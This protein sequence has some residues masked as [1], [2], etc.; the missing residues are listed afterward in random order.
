M[1]KQLLS[2]LL[3][4]FSI[5]TASSA[6]QFF[7]PTPYLQ[8]SDSPFSGGNFAY[9][10]LENFEDRSLNTPGVSANAAGDFLSPTFA[11]SVDADDGIIDGS[12]SQGQALWGG[13]SVP[14]FTF[15]FDANALGGLP[16]HAG[17]VWTDANPTLLGV[18]FEAFGVNG[19]SLGTIG[20]ETLGDGL[21]TGQTAEDRF[22]GVSDPLGI[23]AIS[24]GVSLGGNWELDH[25]QY[26]RQGDSVT[27]PPVPIP[28]ALLLFGSAITGLF[29]LRSTKNKK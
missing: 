1:K 28:S 25:L 7:G 26:G 9:Y 10:H 17:V 27:P 2:L 4:G 22:F 14:K 15:T 12:G 18:T 29:G 13:G 20:P 6:A 24:L 23:S 5:S 3:I 16:T 21:L 19:Q 8:A 11:D